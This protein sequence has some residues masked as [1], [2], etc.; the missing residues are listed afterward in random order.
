[1]ALRVAVSFYRGVAE[2]QETQG[3]VYRA[4]ATGVSG[5]QV[6]SGHGWQTHAQT[7]LVAWAWGSPM[8]RQH[9]VAQAWVSPM[10]RHQV[11]FGHG[12][13]SR[14]QS[15]SVVWA[16]GVARACYTGP[17]P[18]FRYSIL[19]RIQDRARRDETCRGHG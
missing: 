4:Q 7:T 9:Y 5:Q 12:S 17:R 18:F 1:M 6:L 13:T 10:P 16:W 8:P 15:T 14:A 3:P 11:L 19:A 2:G